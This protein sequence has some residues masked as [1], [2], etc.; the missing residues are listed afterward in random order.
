MT[1][2]RAAWFF[3]IAITVIRLAML[4][5]KDLEFDEAHYWLWSDRL[6]PAYFSKGPGI[7]FV[8]RASTA[9]FGANE[10]GVRF[11]SPVLAAASSLLLFYFG[12]RLFGEVAALW[13][14]IAL[15]ATPIFNIGAFLMTIDPLSIFFWT[16]AMLTFWMAI[17]R[18][19][20]FSLYWPATGLL[21][22]LGFLSKYT[23]AL[24]LISV[25]L[26]LAIAPRLRQEFA[27]PG[28][29]WLLGL[30]AL[31]TL[32]PLIWN[33]QH[34]WV[35]LTHLQSRGGLSEDVGIHPWE[36][37]KFLGSHFL[38]YSP[39]LFAAIVLGVIKSFK[40]I[41]QQLKA[42]FL[43]WFGVP[44]FAFYL[45]LSIN[46]VPAPNWDALAFIGFGLLAAYAW[47][48]KLET[49]PWLR[50]GA[51]FAIIVGLLMSMVALDSDLLFSL[52]FRVLRRDP[53]DRMRGWQTATQAIEKLRNEWDA[54]LG[55]KLFL[56]ADDR[57]R[58]S[59]VSF[60]LRDKRIA[61][62]GH[63]PVYL[64]ESQDLANQ[65]YL[66]PRYDEFV[67]APK[68]ATPSEDQP[69]SE[70]GGVNLFTGR[71]A[72]FIRDGANG[73]LL[74]NVRAAFES[75]YPIATMEVLRHGKHIRTWRIF[76]CQHYR[77]LPL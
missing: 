27:R 2:K 58:A 65:F 76:L 61:G 67:T 53:S 55:E 75:A 46:K 43:F 29:Y 14:I 56:I 71:S 64:V 40:R 12:R 30:F 3:V 68:P 26:V 70:E 72:L 73:S 35:T 77:T 66:W 39:F 15:N 63:P 41:N 25:I 37:L 60:Y 47:R 38:F 19:P 9:I 11:P 54:K 5:T 32:P 50:G 4:M 69:Y 36:P 24:E 13:L 7:A 1:T 59:E 20:Q 74:H 17:E 8:I 33:S 21:I 49:S 44:V 22:G 34:A 57:D 31:C 42:L 28:L 23:N 16:A 45:L 6:A 48:D 52:G 18:S 10:F 62:P 51:C